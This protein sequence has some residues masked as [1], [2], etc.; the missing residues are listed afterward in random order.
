MMKKVGLLAYILIAMAANAFA[1]TSYYWVKFT[2]KNNNGYSI[3]SPQAFL[4][5]KSI[6]RRIKS[7]IAIDESDLPITQS[8]I[9]AI[10][11]YTERIVHRLKW[12]NVAVI[13]VDESTFNPN[14]IRQLSFVD[15]LN[16]IEFIP[17]R[18]AKAKFEEV[19][20]VVDQNYYYPNTTYGIAYRQAN[21]LNTD[22]LHQIGHRGNGVII[23]IMDNGFNNVD[24]IRG[25]DSIRTHILATWDFVNND[26]NVYDGGI[27]GTNVL[28]CIGGNIKGKYLG[29]AP[30]ASFLLLQS[31]DTGGEW[32]ME[33]Y[34]WAAAA[35][36]AD[37]A[38]ADLFSTSLGYTEF[39]N[40]TGSHT[41]ADLS[42]DKT[43]IT[44]AA[45]QAFDKG[46]LV[47]NSA[48]N[49]G[50]E[51]W[52]YIGAPAD[53]NKVMA[54]GAVD[55]A[56]IIAAFSSR[57]PRPDGVIKPDVCAQ[58]VRSAVITANGDIGYSAG[59]SF[60][61]PTLAG[62]AASLWSA[63]PSKT[64]KEIYDAIMISCDRFWLP[65]NDYG[66]GIP[67]FYT[68]YQLL[69]SDYNSKIFTDNY[70]VTVFPNPSSQVL[71]IAVS[72]ALE[73]NYS[74]ELYDMLGNKVLEQEIFIRGGT[75]ELV[76]LKNYSNIPA[77][78]YLLVF[79]GRRSQTVK[80]IKGN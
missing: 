16:K 48:G 73:K 74:I 46:I 45:N 62:S 32:V 57:G 77:G 6:D 50:N 60:S 69:K 7:N 40:G 75:Y 54:V 34:N 59:T 51:D 26:N 3:A 71:Y 41:Y 19:Y 11:P 61:C 20:P 31:E 25:F 66:Y 76:Q 12:I 35:E 72:D 23:A 2:D 21:M 17:S 28:S 38:G 18:S 4:S 55:S 79:D 78:K 53:G 42:G 33:E 49:E 43:V 24:N 8:Y 67:D 68:A 5:I 22:L 65:N 9:D 30:D 70:K 13:A 14:S 80:V 39:D 29:T 64:P 37:S 15:S 58:G 56:E 63:F 47:I 27:H 36:W 1:Q 44:H 10:T 52:Y